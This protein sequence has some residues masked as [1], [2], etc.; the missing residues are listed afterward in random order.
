MTVIRSIRGLILRVPGRPHSGWLPRGAASPP[1][2]A[3][4]VIEVN[5]EI[6]AVEPPES[7]FLLIISSS[8]DPEFADDS[9]HETLEL[10]LQQAEFQYGIVPSDWEAGRNIAGLPILPSR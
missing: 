7:G 9:W 2:I 10:A 1:G 3:T 8:G 5:L 6:E 4:K